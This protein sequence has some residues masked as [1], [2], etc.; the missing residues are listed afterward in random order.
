MAHAYDPHATRASSD[1]TRGNATGAASRAEI[2]WSD[3]EAVSTAV[4]EA[5]SD[6]NDTG[7]TDIGPIYDEAD[8]ES[9]GRFL[10]HRRRRS[11]EH[12][13]SATFTVNGYTVA[14]QGDEV[15]VT[16]TE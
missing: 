14:V 12:E 10:T 3:P 2:D 5:L 4:I 1:F 13:T 9:L 11:A 6:A 16:E 7:P 8:L 15:V